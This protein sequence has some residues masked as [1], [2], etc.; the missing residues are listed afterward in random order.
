MNGKLISI[1]AALAVAANAAVVMPGCASASA[2]EIKVMY[3][4]RELELDAA[5]QIVNDTT[6]VPMRA[7]F[8]A[9]GAKVKWDSDTQSVTAKKKSKTIAMTI[10]S[11]EI[12]KN[13]K[14][15]K[16]QTAPQIIDGRTMIPVRAV[17]E[18]LGLNVDW[19][20]DDRTVVITSSSD[21]ADDEWKNNTGTIDLTAMTADADGVSIEGN[22]ITITKGGDYTVSGQN[23]NASITVEARDENGDKSK[24]KLRLNGA[25]LTSPAGAAIN[26]TAADKLYI[27]LEDGTENVISDG[28]EYAD[29]EINACIYSKDDIE[30]KGNGSLTV[31]GNRNHGITCNDSME[32]ANGNVTINSKNDGIHVNDTMLIS[33]GAVNITAEGDGI[34][35]DEI[36]DITGGTVNVTTTGAVE[37]KSNNDMFMRGFKRG[38]AEPESSSEPESS[39]EP[40]AAAEAEEASDVSSKGIKSGWMLTVNGGTINVSSTDHA[41]H[42]TGEIDLNSGSLTLAS[43]AGKGISGH[44]DVNLNGTTVNITEATEG[45]ESKQIVTM[46]DGDINITCSDDGL[47]AGGGAEFGGGNP[48]GGGRPGMPGEMNGERPEMPEGINGERPEVPDGM[49]GERPEIPDGMDGEG[50]GMPGGMGGAG[51]RM[52]GGMNGE[53]AEMPDGMNSEQSGMPDGMKG[54]K[55]EMPQGANRE[56]RGQRS[57]GTQNTEQNPNEGIGGMRHEG[58]MGGRPESTEISTEHHIQINGGTLTINAEG[59]GIDSNGSIVMDGGYVVVNGP[60]RSGDSAIDHDGLCQ[61]NGG[62][63]IALGSAGMIENPSETSGQNVISAYLTKVCGAGETITIRDSAGNEVMNVTPVKECGHIMFSSDAIKDGETYTVYEN[64]T[65]GNSAAVSSKLT[66]MR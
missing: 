33:G 61:V 54:E 41:V 39:P 63:L 57:D 16:A 49:N 30:I 50:P 38:A 34:S 32:I 37:S 53:R 24:V 46:N 19:N 44:E 62:T 10:G 51:Q 15:V 31:N 23:S 29:D 8:E 22:V 17:S 55:S 20:S 25:E 5:P 7:V 47:N 2:D 48:M 64:G 40:T 58:G 43:S 26:V 45:I 66:I 14:T 3:D 6:L 56:K 28:G 1:S 35:A 11:D 52:R 4:G 42:S 27:T 65:E 18:L 21:E 13:D 12:T 59:D 60:S 9:F 36:F